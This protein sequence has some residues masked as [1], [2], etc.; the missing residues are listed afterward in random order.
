M[1]VVALIPARGG[2]KGLP[3]KNKRL[4]SGK[5]LISHTIDAAKEAKR[6]TGIFVSSDC[7]D[8]LHIGKTLGV[9]CIRRPLELATDEA[10]SE[11]VIEHAITHFNL[12]NIVADTIVLLQPTSPLRN[13]KHIDEALDVYFHR[14]ANMVLSVF[15][16]K[17]TP[18]KAYI[19]TNEGLH[20]LYNASAPYTRR[21][22]LPRAFQ[23]NGAIYVINQISYSQYN[24]FPRTRV[25]PYVMS[26]K[27]SLDIDTLDDF[28]QIEQLMKVE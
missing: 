24:L 12:H 6:I 1:S 22:D 19:E 9:Q 8:I 25:F 28:L 16:P 3:K 7:E 17:H 10:S 23:P 11:S 26:E 18:I 27:L 20:G 4:L 13:G 2:S 5:P 15:E 14:N 21:Q